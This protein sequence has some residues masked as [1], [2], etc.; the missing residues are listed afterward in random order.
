VVPTLKNADEKMNIISADIVTGY[1]LTPELSIGGS[2]EYFSYDD[3]YKSHQFL[4]QIEERAKLMVDYESNGWV[5]NLT[6]T[7]VG[8]RDLSEYGYEGWNRLADIGDSNLAKDTNAP[9]YYT[10][11]MKVSKEVNKNFTLYAGVKNLF[12]YTQA[13]DE[14]TPLFYDADGGYDVGYIYGPLRGRQFYAGLQAKF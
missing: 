5:A 8:S 13:G 6:A 10:V 9:D 14:D 12:D 4:A 3:A 7:W 11:D 1:Q 2:F